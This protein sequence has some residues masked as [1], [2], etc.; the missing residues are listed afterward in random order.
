MR[1]IKFKVWDK[2]EN[3]ILDDE[4]NIIGE[5]AAFSVEQPISLK[6]IHEIL[7]NQERFKFLE[8][9]GLK[10]YKAKMIFEGDILYC[11][12][13]DMEFYS[14]VYFEDG[15]FFIGDERGIKSSVDIYT[16]DWT[17][18]CEVVGNKYDNPELIENA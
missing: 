11:L 12:K 5:I 15:G 8:Y 9:T 10:D 4:A 13:G 14:V 3:R 17:G 18:M 16:G 6:T 2:E 1:E 7:N